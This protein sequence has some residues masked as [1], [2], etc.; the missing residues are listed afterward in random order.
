VNATQALKVSAA[1]VGIAAI[2]MLAGADL[3]PAVPAAKLLLY[4]ACAASLPE[5][6]QP[7]GA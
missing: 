2:V 6:R 1:C 4:A 5:A 3:F 7:G